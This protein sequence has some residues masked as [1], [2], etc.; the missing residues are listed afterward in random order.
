MIYLGKIVYLTSVSLP[1]QDLQNI[2]GYT[3]GQYDFCEN[4][5]AQMWHY[6]A[7]QKHL[8]STDRLTVSKYCDPAP[9]TA[10]FPQSS[11]GRSGLFIGY[12][13]VE[14]YLENNK[15]VTLEQLMEDNDSQMILEKS[16]YNPR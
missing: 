6:I 11:P 7:E 9:S 3:R 10:Y 12:K 5:E 1:N 8:F 4:N 13:I 16:G 15:D 2:L 14:S